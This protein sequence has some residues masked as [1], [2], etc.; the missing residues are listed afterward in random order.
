MDTLA[1]FVDED[2]F[3]VISALAATLVVFEFTTFTELVEVADVNFTEFE[4]LA[5]F[6]GPE[7]LLLSPSKLLTS[8]FLL[9]L[10]FVRLS[11]LSLVAA[12]TAAFGLFGAFF[13]CQL[14]SSMDTNF[15]KR[16]KY[17]L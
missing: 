15:F 12:P 4:L 16:S 8:L 1:G 11:G 5:E 6:D 10:L 14:T 17:W 3:V 13:D 2:E 9:S 7:L